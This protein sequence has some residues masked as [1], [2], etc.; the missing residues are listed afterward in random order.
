MANAQLHAGRIPRLKDYYRKL[1]DNMR[2]AR[3]TSNAVAP[4][5]LFVY[6]SQ[7][8]VAGAQADIQVQQAW[9]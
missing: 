4:G 7:G 3:K 1:E 5:H 8:N 6:V 9:L 2:V